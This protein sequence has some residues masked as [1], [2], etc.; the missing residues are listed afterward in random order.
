[1]LKRPR[2]LRGGTLL[3]EMVRET[4]ISPS[5]LILPLF[6]KEGKDIHDPIP[7]LEGHFHLSPDDQVCREVE[8][9]LKA[10][11][12]R[13]LLFGLPAHKDPEGSGAYDDQGIVQQ[14]LRVLKDHFGKDIY[15][16]TDICM[17]EYTSHGHCGIL[18]GQEVDNDPTLERLARIAVSHAQAGADMVAPSDMMDGRV[19][20][21][22]NALDEAGRTDL[23]ILSYAV[24]Y[25]SSFYGPFR[26][27][28]GSAPAFG[29]RKSY[30]MD[31]HNVREALKEALSLIHI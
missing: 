15:L 9:A 3:R 16:V 17:C 7:S 28:A 29:D 26:D 27:A 31:C 22:R 10:G 1:M 14:G 8:Q 11:V 13:F 19:L 4:R 2:R 18:H 20:A 25:A 24:K 30:Q 12:S 5:S 6:L 23:P 21:I